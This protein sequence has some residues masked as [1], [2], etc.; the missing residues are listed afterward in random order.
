MTV[1]V[2]LRSPEEEKELIAFLNKKHFDY[3]TNPD[4]LILTTEQER[5]I[6]RRD[7]AFAQGKTNAR[8]WDEI[9]KELENVYR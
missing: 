4:S 2:N 1:L 5:E 9:R 6:I 7:E 3:Q 8:D